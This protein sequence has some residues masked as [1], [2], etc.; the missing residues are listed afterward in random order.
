MLLSQL[1]ECVEKRRGEG[2]LRQLTVSQP[3]LVDFCSNDYLGLARC[4][5]LAAMIEEE[6]KE[7]HSLCGST[8]SRLLTG[9]CSYYEQV[10]KELAVIYRGESALLANSGFDM[11]IGLFAALP[12]PGDYVV[13]DELMHNSAREGMKLSR[14]TSISFKHNDVRDLKTKLE[15]LG[16]ANI[17]VAVESVYSMDGH[18]APLEEIV[19][20][21]DQ[22][23]ANLVVDEAHGVGVFGAQGEGLV[24]KLNLESKVFCRVYTFGKAPGVHGAV[25]VGPKALRDY[26]INYCK[27]LIY[28]TSLPMHSVCSIR[29]SH[30]RMRTECLLRQRHLYLLVQ[31]FTDYIRNSPTLSINALDSPS[32]IQGVIVPGNE[33]VVRVSN[34]LK[35]KGWNVLPIR[36]PTVPKNSERLR[37]ILH[38][39]NS[40]DQLNGLLRHLEEALCT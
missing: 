39:H 18:C 4:T 23:N 7:Q 35:A 24:V 32:A 30:E 22:F 11:N 2:L 28:S 14:G 21:C 34:F 25:L 26:M 9:N 19:S 27:P 16:P 12:Q 17:I 29:A 15:A 31:H 40:I 20:I 5:Q 33:K 10:E 3:G 6:Y 1:S 13:Y 38:F 36:S 37:I 8:G